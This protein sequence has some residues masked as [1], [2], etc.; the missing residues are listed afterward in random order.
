[1]SYRLRGI[2]FAIIAMLLVPAA[3]QTSSGETQQGFDYK[4]ITD[5]VVMLATVAIAYYA[6]STDR[7][8][9]IGS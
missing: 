6:R 1:M 2:V 7:A 8:P 4:W 9:I 5:L 3:A